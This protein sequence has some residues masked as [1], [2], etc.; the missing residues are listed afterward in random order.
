MPCGQLDPCN[1]EQ[2]SGPNRYEREWLPWSDV[3]SGGHRLSEHSDVIVVDRAKYA[4]NI[5]QSLR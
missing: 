5:G 3:K 4:G 2:L 1:G